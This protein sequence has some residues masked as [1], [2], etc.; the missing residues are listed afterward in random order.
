MKGRNPVALAAV[1]LSARQPVRLRLLVVI[2]G[3]TASLPPVMRL[4]LFQLL[5]IVVL[6][7]QQILRDGQGSVQ[8]DT[9]PRQQDPRRGNDPQVPDTIA[10]I[11]AEVESVSKDV[12]PQ[13]LH[14]VK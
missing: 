14:V 10:M 8:I 13:R 9:L 1:T 2:V 6:S 7:R 5:V 4:L 11:L 3:H 12:L